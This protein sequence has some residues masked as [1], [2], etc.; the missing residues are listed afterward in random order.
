[1]TGS[2]NYLSTIF[3]LVTFF[4]TI[5][6]SYYF[7]KYGVQD[8]LP[9]DIVKACSQDSLG[10]LWIA[11]DE[12]V[13]KYD[14]VSFTTYPSIAH[15]N[16][17]KGFL[18]TRDGRLLVY[19]DLD[20]YEIVNLEDTVIFNQLA[21]TSRIE[22][23][24]SVSFPKALYEDKK[25]S[26]WITEAESV[27]RLEPGVFKRYQ[28]GPSNR[29][30]QFLRSFALFED[31]QDNLY[32]VSYTGNTFI[33]DRGND[34]FKPYDVDL[35]QQIEYT[36]VINN[37]LLIGA[38]EG[39]FFAEL[40]PNGGI[41]M[42]EQVVSSITNISCIQQLANNQYFIAT[43]ESTHYFADAAL[44]NISAVPYKIDDIN[45]VYLSEEQD[46]WVSGNDGLI[47]LKEN[48]FQAISDELFIEAITENPEG[49]V[50]Y[51]A[52]AATL[53]K[54]NQS[55]RENEV[56][57]QVEDGYFQDLLFT[58]KGLWVANAFKVFLYQDQKLIKE[59]DFTDQSQFV[60]KLSLD[61]K[62][63]IWVTIQENSTVLRIDDQLQLESHQLS[64]SAT[65]SINMIKEGL[66][67]IYATA[68][69]SDSYIYQMAEGDSVFQNISLPLAFQTNSSLEVTDMV[70]VDEKIYLASSA[71]LLTYDQ[72]NV[73]RVDLKEFTSLPIRSI[74][75]YQNSKLLL[76]NAFGMLVYDLK[77]GVTDLFNESYGLASRTIAP[78]GIVVGSDGKVWV[79]TSKGLC[80]SSNS[81]SG[82]R[83][84]ERPRIIRGEVNGQKASKAREISANYRDF[85]SLKLSS[86]T[87][88]ERDVNYQYRFDYENNWT[89]F[90]DELTLPLLEPGSYTLEFR[91]EKY[92]PYSWSDK[93]RVTLEIN[94]LFWQKWWFILLV[95]LS[96]I[97]LIWIIYWFLEKQ[98][99]T[100][101]LRLQAVVLAK[102]KMLQEAND[103]LTILNEEKNNLI[104]IVAHDLKSPLAQILGLVDLLI[105]DKLISDDQ[106]GILHMVKKATNNQ[107]EMIHRI[108]DINQ[109]ES[110]KL[111]IKMEEMNL[112][113]LLEALIKRNEPR[114]SEK[115]IQIIGEIPQNIIIKSDKGYVRQIMDN[116]LSNAIKF[117]P[118]K[119][120][121][122][123]KAMVSEERVLCEVKDQGPGISKEDQ[124]KLFKK[125]QRLSATPTGNESSTGLGLS[126]VEKFVKAIGAEIWIESDQG[127][128]SSFY[129]A[130][131][132][133]QK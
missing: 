125:Y 20:L 38:T 41:Q 62:E 118:K 120:S 1:M 71:G 93:S 75:L 107:V 97:L 30:T 58:P 86:I 56:M 108:L 67:G 98:N 51:Y 36:E 116:L 96:T 68:S 25:G 42:P 50:C 106:R 16:Y 131:S 102:T 130:L 112:T 33:Y 77:S 111:C 44:R 63:N 79:G 76:A 95:L 66:D 70:F 72:N 15:S 48:L 49:K 69:G 92:G 85:I 47:L 40:S 127:K 12:G 4:Q 59:F 39:L 46:M 84:T 129:V 74:A 3:L 43:R 94:A 9:S 114:A 128:G 21:P 8:G 53:Y 121:I 82:S 103:N 19:G 10:Y 73:T 87:F 35:P 6:Q 83:K 132:Q 89:S 34:S 78:N 101:N 54:R 105:D 64:S 90:S 5:G 55:T 26:L 37:N 13:A 91:A 18:K 99:R 133:N 45:S 11:T 81:L 115:E 29:T 32:V 24:S 123:L 60:S 52:D 23:D 117:S 14:G 28:F 22:N 104:G 126:I 110:K 100:K 17:F 7:K 31:L 113:E 65:P 27:V 122:H 109:I 124:K 80:T 119:S 57:L 2:R 88:P 61:S